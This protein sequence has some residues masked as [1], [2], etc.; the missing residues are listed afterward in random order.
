M[1]TIGVGEL[2]RDASGV[3]RR[4][5]QGER[6]VVTLH[7]RPVADLVPHTE[8]RPTWRPVADLAALFPAV[9]DPDVVADLAMVD[10]AVDDPFE[11]DVARDC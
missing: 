5:A 9:G 2:R 6:V 11:R 4:V 3:L 1:T 8:V 7:G 10:S